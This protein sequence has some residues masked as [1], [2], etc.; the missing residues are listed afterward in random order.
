MVICNFSSVCYIQFIGD[1][2]HKIQFE[3]KKDTPQ[4]PQDRYKVHKEENI[5]PDVLASFN[6]YIYM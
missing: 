6:I 3:R 2:T 5:K 4:K 1:N